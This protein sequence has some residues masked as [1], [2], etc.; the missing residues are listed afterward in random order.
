M[1][2]Y[3]TEELKR[4]D[5]SGL[6]RSLKVVEGAQG[7]SVMIDGRSR[8]LFCSNDYLGLAGHP[9]V[10]EAASEALQKYGMGAGASRLVSGSM[11]PHRELEERVKT[12]MGTEA[13]LV[14]NSGYNAN[15]GCITVLASRDTEIFSDRSNH[16][17]IVDGCVLSR[18]KV[19]RYKSSDAGSLERMLK[20]STARRKLVITEGVFSMDGN[21]APLKEIIALMDRYGAML[22]LDDAHA[23]GTLGASGRGTLEHLG[24]AHPSIIRVGTFSK[25]LGVFGAFVA[26]SREAVELLI[27]RARPFIYTTALPPSVSAAVIKAL[28]IAEEGTELRARLRQNSD[29]M[30][31]GLRAMGLDTLG[32]ETHIIPVLVG[33]AQRAVEISAALFERGVFIQ[34]IRPP[35]VPDG[36]ARLRVTVSAAHSKEDL[37]SALSAIKEVFTGAGV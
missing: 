36:T 35:T 5:G 8:L 11:A 37:E 26:G 33:S 13:A 24:L 29:Y 3:I 14:F 1:D 16:A 6:R 20:R 31:D 9:L 10:K 2:A 27:S 30:R 17:S 12:F 21:I 34:G 32:S 28:E 18:A 7:P 19:S 4:L 25:A 15:I 22:L 23:V